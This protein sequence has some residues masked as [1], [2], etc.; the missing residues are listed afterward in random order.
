MIVLNKE[1]LSLPGHCHVIRSFFGRFVQKAVTLCFSDSLFQKQLSN[2]MAPVVIQAIRSFYA[3][4]SQS[5]LFNS[6]N[7]YETYLVCKAY[8]CNAHDADKLCFLPN[9]RYHIILIGEIDELLQK[10]DAFC[11]RYQH[12]HCLC[13]LSKNWFSGKIVARRGQVS[14]DVQRA[15]YFNQ[16]TEEW[17]KCPALQK[18]KCWE[19][20]TKS[21]YWALCDR[22]NQRKQLDQSLQREFN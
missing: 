10:V 14:D 5:S 6:A 1:I 16:I 19:K 8:Y 13:T 20:N 2:Q 22:Q 12:V 9:C 7:T 21:I 4:F 17:T 11:F 15:V 3:N 18:R